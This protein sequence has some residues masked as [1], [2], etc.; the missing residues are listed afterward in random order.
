MNDSRNNFENGWYQMAGAGFCIG[1]ALVVGLIGSIM[2]RM[3]NQR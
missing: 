1:I 2:A 3:F